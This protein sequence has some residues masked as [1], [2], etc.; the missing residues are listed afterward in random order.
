MDADLQHPPEKV[1]DMVKALE[2][3]EFVIGTR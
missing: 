1:P 2:R 3:E